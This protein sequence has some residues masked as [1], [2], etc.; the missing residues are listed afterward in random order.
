MNRI[1]IIGA[2]KFGKRAARVV[3]QQMPDADLTILD[4]NPDVC[5]KLKTKGFFTVCMD[6]IDFLTERLVDKESVDWIVPAAPIHVAFE[7]IKAR[8]SAPFRLIPIKIPHQLAGSLPNAI[9]GDSGELYVGNADFICPANCPEPSDLCTHTGLPRPRI[10]HR[11]ISGVRYRHFHSVVIISRQMYPGVGGY[12]G[13]DLL[14][15]FK[16]VVGAK[17]PLFF[18]TACRCHGVMHGLKIERIT[19]VNLI[20]D[21]LPG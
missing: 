9:R 5:R 12:S 3:R 14:S 1:W 11:A 7:W 10:L 16:E 17:G 18:S 21:E 6:G 19:D 2:G 20:K 15:A 4:Q 8:I 13:R